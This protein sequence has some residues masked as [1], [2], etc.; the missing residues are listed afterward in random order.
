[1]DDYKDE[2]LNLIYRGWEAKVKDWLLNSYTLAVVIQTPLEDIFNK[3]LESAEYR[4]FLDLY[5]HQKMWYN[6]KL[7]GVC[8]CVAG[9][10]TYFDKF[11]WPPPTTEEIEDNPIND[12]DEFNPEIYDY[13]KDDWDLE[14]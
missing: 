7:I 1:M 11:G 3:M 9:L 5:L 10:E 4:R 2:I 13:D 8:P 6:K 12:P 14:N